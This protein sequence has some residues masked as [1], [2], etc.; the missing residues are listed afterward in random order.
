MVVELLSKQ[1]RFVFGDQSLINL[2][3]WSGN[4]N[5]FCFEIGI[6][7]GRFNVTVLIDFQC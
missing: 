1:K 4:R 2:L 3:L 5:A 6:G 7:Y